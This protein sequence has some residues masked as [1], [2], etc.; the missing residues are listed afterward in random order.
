LDLGSDDLRDEEA[1]LTYGS[2]SRATR[3]TDRE[4]TLAVLEFM[5]DNFPRFSLKLFLEQLFTWDNASVKNVANSYLAT[6][7]ADSGGLHLL[8]IAIGD[9]GMEKSDIGDWIMARATEICSKEV[10]QLTTRASRGP[11]FADTQYLR[12]PA[13]DI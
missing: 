2:N 7:G 8:E 1:D 5:K 10:T 9:K 12:V 4:K 13:N 6:G 11:H 3:F